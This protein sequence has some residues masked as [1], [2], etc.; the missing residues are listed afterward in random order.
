MFYLQLLYDVKINHIILTSHQ[1]KNYIR[2]YI[3]TLLSFIQIVLNNI[4][5]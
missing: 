5:I 3:N 1:R 2:Y 4:N